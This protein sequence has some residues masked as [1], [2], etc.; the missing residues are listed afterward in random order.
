MDNVNS[1]RIPDVNKFSDSSKKAIF[2]IC[3]D[4]MLF[5]IF[6]PIALNILEL[7][8][9]NSPTLTQGIPLLIYVLALTL[10]RINI[11]KRPLAV[12][13]SFVLL[14]IFLV[15]PFELYAR[16]LYGIYAVLMLALSIKQFFKPSFKFFKTFF[17]ICGEA[18]LF[19]NLFC[20][21]GANNSSVKELTLFS[22][23]AFSLIFLFY[24]SR[25]RY[26]LLIASEKD[27]SSSNAAN[28]S[29]KKFIIA[30]FASFL[31][32]IS[33]VLLITNKL[34]SNSDY[35]VVNAI[36]TA[37]HSQMPQSPADLKPKDNLN[38]KAKDPTHLNMGK[39]TNKQKGNSELPMY[40]YIITFLVLAALIIFIGFKIVKLVVNSKIKIQEADT[41][42]ETEATFLTEDLKKDLGSI[43]P[44][45]NFNLSNREKLRKY[46]KK[47]ISSYRK[48]GLRIKDSSTSIELKDGI[49][50]LTGDDIDTATK[51][52]N[53]SRYSLYE[54]TKED[55]DNLRKK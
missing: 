1:Y 35:A 7:L 32:F 25:S 40:A 50:N 11:K 3:E 36:Y 46:Y 13:L 31:I 5:I 30:L 47:L 24:S 16:F 37:L 54:P 39:I 53:K 10:I 29:S 15:I 38:K 20:A 55:I 33:C 19:I 43:I 27:N 17:F 12:I 9:K 18:L 48:K 22:A 52:Y 4:I 42:A 14:C 45:F 6:Y 49:L 8:Y 34:N 21:Y 23:I 51:I 2:Q 44:K 28:L 26:K 41:D